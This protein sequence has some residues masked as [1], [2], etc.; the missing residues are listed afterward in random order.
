MVGP[1]NALIKYEQRVDDVQG[2]DRAQVPTIVE[3]GE[4]D[5][6]LWT[7]VVKTVLRGKKLVGTMTEKAVETK[8]NEKALALIVPA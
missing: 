8:T 2:E 6:Q 7:L 1:P 3:K 5:F 4:D